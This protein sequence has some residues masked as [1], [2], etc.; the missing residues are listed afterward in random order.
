MRVVIQRVSE[1]AVTIEGK[2]HGEIQQGLLLLLGIEI[3]DSEED[4]KLLVSKINKLR[5]FSDKEDLMNLSCIDVAGDYLVISQFTLFADTK[6]GNRPS[7][8][9]AARP[10]Q[11][12]PLY[13]AF[14]IMLEMESKRKVATGIFGTDMKVSLVN[15][16]PVTIIIDTKNKDY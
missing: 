5:I 14:I 10:E 11:A 15:N 13:E 9:R 12:K 8:I 16:G 7:Y 2:I 3:N 6:K 4:V 1:A